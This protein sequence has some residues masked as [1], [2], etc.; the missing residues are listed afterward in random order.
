MDYDTY[1]VVNYYQYRLD[2]EKANLPNSTPE[3]ELNYNPKDLYG[4][5]DL[6]PSSW[7]NLS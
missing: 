6:S 4:M 1:Q 5:K 7:K 3:F 2:L